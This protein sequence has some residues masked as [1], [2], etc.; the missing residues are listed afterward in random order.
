M[1]R[2][3]RQF[4]IEGTRWTLA[5]IHE[6]CDWLRTV[7]IGGVHRLLER[8]RVTWKQARAHIHSPDPAYLEK[9]AFITD[10]QQQVRASDGRLVLLYLDEFTYYRQPAVA[11]AYDERG[12][13]QPLAELS[14]RADTLTRIVG[15]LNLVDGRVFFLRRKKIGLTILVTF[16]RMI[17]RAFPTAERIYV[18]QDNWPNH[19]HP[20]VLVALEPQ[21]CRW[22]YH[23]PSNWPVEPNPSARRQYEGLHLPI[24]L[25]PLPTYASWTNPIEK[26]WRKGRQEVLHLHRLADQLDELRAQFD[27]FLSA[28]ANGSCELLRYVGL[29]PG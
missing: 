23:Q 5:A 14:C 18:V 17:R 12:R 2:D 29:S 10:L 25:V 19:F 20:D 3:P 11:H 9:L 16:Y 26:L 7:S 1:R 6:V 28:F 24:Q 21:D 22:P 15:A 27:H 13:H 8:L 4:G